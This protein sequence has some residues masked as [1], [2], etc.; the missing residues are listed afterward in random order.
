MEFKI[1]ILI[2][3]PGKT[4]TTFLNSVIPNSN[5]I[6]SWGKNSFEKNVKFRKKLFFFIKSLLGQ[7]RL[8]FIP[9]YI[10]L[11]LRNEEKLRQSL[12]WNDFEKNLFDYKKNF[13]KKYRNDRYLQLE[14]FI[15]AVYENTHYTPYK[16]WYKENFF[17]C[18]SI[19]GFI[20]SDFQILIKNFGKSKFI[21][22][23][24][25]NLKDL[26]KIPDLNIIFSKKNKVIN[27][28]LEFWYSDI[29]NKVKL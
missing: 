12:F 22:V 8:F 23:G 13:K 28:K 15:K 6:H 17:L 18:P 29:I 24:I 1:N 25:N 5:V 9:H 21:I 4:A 16:F 11:P 27:S 2:F 14:S 10:I 3:S 19:N 26:E 20:N 7:L